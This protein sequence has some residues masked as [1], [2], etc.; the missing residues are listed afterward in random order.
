MRYTAP[1]L[2][3]SILPAQNVCVVATVDGVADVTARIQTIDRPFL[4]LSVADSPLLVYE[5]GSPT[6]G[7]FW[8]YIVPAYTF[9]DG[10]MERI[11]AQY[12]AA[13]RLPLDYLPA[14]EWW[15][16]AGTH[17]GYTDTVTVTVL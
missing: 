4:L 7:W 14:G 15:F 3:A 12:P 9:R 11:G 8:S 1:L 2:L 17:L 6:Y 13:L 5:V 16:R 10:A